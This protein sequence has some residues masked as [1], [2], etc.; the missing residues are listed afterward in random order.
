MLN[1][2]M[3]HLSRLRF[4]QKIAALPIAAGTG[5]LLILVFSMLLSTRASA[6][7]MRRSCCSGP[8][9]SSYG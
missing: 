5:F 6:S 1:R 4:A 9:S 8:N 3:A 7:I 2:L